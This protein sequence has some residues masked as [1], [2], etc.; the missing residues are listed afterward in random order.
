MFPK[1]FSFSFL[2]L[3]LI[4]FYSFG[5]IK[6]DVDP[7]AI[8]FDSTDVGDKSDPE[9]ITVRNTGTDKFYI[10][11]IGLTG[12]DE[13]FEIVY[14]DCEKSVLNEGEECSIEV[15]F[16]PETKGV[17]AAALDIKIIGD[18]IKTE[19]VALSGVATVGGFLEI[20]P[21]KHDF[22]N[23]DKGDSKSYTFTLE[24]KSN[25]VIEIKEIKLE[26]DSDNFKLNLNGGANPCAVQT[27]TLNPGDSCTIEIIFEPNSNGVKTSTLAVKYELDG[28]ELYS[29]AA[30]VGTAGDFNTNLL[31]L[32]IEPSSKDFGDVEIGDRKIIEITI[33]N[34]GDKLIQVK[35]I[36]LKELEIN[37]DDDYYLNLNGGTNPCGS[38]NF[39][40]N[41]E[42]SCTIELVF[43][44]QDKGTQKAILFI[45]YEVDGDTS[46]TAGFYT[47]KGI[48]GGNGG[49]GG[50]SFMVQSSTLPFYLL[51]PLLLVIRRFVKRD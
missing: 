3:L 20:S 35:D 45:K 32:K 34:D 31:D 40:L 46:Y 4:S 51:I 8:V 30:L 38:E 27:L 11:D 16:A 49:D 9:I 48:E 25:E 5:S 7:Q 17:K 15:V 6:V 19:E 33:K 14:E 21:S 23:V 2:V 13:D 28:A 26:L 1:R 37:G 12:D 39:T 43:E 50:C 18:G 22:G 10:L 41:P 42:T 44:P 29:A 36:S 47:G 24:N